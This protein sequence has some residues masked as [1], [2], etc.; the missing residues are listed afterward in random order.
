MPYCEAGDPDYV[1]WQKTAA[2]KTGG[3]WFSTP[4]AS[5]CDA[6]ADGAPCA[7]RVARVAK[8]V[9]RTC[10]AAVR[11]GAIERFF[12][13]NYSCPDSGLGRRRNASSPCWL[14]AF[15]SAVLGPGCGQ[16]DCAVAG[17]PD[18]ALT[19]AWALPFADPAA[20]GCAPLAP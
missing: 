13:A 20:G 17:L 10:A 12:P 6:V 15:F 19:R 2:R 18:A 1:C 5:A 11:L 16:P 7:W 8:V 9:N 4:A 3:A 14:A